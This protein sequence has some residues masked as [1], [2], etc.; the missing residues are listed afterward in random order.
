MGGAEGYIRAHGGEET[1]VLVRTKMPHTFI[2]RPTGEPIR[3]DSLFLYSVEM[4]GEYGYWTQCIRPIFMKRGAF[5]EAERILGIIKEAEVAGAE[6]MVPGNRVC[7]VAEAIEHVVAKYNL[8]IGV[9]SG[10][11]MGADLGDGVDIGRSNTMEIVP[12]MILTLHP[13]VQSDI[14]GLL[15]GNTWLATEDKPVNLTPEYADACFID[16]LQAQIK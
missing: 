3:E 4:A 15:Y 14:D 1:L 5:P 2:A 7:D 10:H 12:N 11:G 8:R 16:E 13:S 6:K 9:W